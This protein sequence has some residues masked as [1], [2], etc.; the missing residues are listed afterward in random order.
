MTCREKLKI[1]HPDKVDPECLGGAFCCPSFY[2]YL[3][4]PNYCSTPPLASICKNCWDREIPEDKSE[5]EDE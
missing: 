3:D 2:G 5:T 4:T 1:E